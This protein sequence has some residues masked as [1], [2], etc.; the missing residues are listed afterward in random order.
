VDL[1]YKV[2]N[3]THALEG[4]IWMAKIAKVKHFLF[5]KLIIFLACPNNCA[6]CTS[7]SMC[8][9]CKSGFGLQS[10]QC[11]TCPSGTWLNGQN[12]QSKELKL[13]F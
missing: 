5:I 3:A 13:D 8:Q 6:T 10:N 11:E 12:C 2:I 7:P 9:T 1:V 4:L